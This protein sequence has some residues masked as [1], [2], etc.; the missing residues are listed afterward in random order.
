MHY[1]KLALL[2]LISCFCTSAWAQQTKLDILTDI[3]PVHSLVSMVAGEQANIDLLVQ[4]NQSP[5]DFVLKPSQVQSIQRAQ[6]IIVLESDVSPAI[7]QYVDSTQSKATVLTLAQSSEESHDWLSPTHAINWLSAISDALSSLDSENAVRYAQQATR[8]QSNL[9]MLQ[10]ELKTQ[11]G[12]IKDKS[13][14]VYHNAYT[15]FADAFDLQTPTAIAQSD[16]RS[17]G[18][19]RILKVRKIAQHS[20]CIFSE[21]QHNDGYIDTV[22]EG[23][24]IGHG[25]LDPLGSTIP[26]G[27]EHYPLMMRNLVDELQRCMG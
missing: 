15:Q 9:H 14:I 20:A 24:D 6:L 8:A 5:H 11:L 3:A 17:P 27:T 16:A 4:P 13:F 10:Q 22:S 19:A 26:L 12:P 18:A 23:L 25:T 7:L 2:T 21:A 1:R